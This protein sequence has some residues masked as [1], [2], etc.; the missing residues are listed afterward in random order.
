MERNNTGDFQTD[1]MVTL[2]RLETHIE[3]LVGNGQPGKIK[4]IEDKRIKSLA[5]WRLDRLSGRN[6]HRCSAFSAQVLCS[7]SNTCSLTSKWN[8]TQKTLL[9]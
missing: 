4:L 3:S 8:I 1:V 2:E 7:R 9:G 5:N 6:R